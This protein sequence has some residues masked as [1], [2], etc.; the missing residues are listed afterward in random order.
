MSTLISRLY[1]WATDKTNGVKI[2]ASKMDAENDQII[3]ALN[4]KVLCS[5][6]A[7]DS[8]IAGQTWVDTTN[9]LLKVYLDN[10]WKTISDDDTL[11]ASIL[12][13]MYPVGSVYIN[14]S[15]ATNPGT[16]LGFG[17][18][19][20]FGAGKVLVGL[21]AA[22]EDFDTAEETGGAKT[23][24][25]SHTHT[26]TTDVANAGTGANSYVQGDSGTHADWS[27][28]THD[29]TTDSGGSETQSVVQP[30]ITV[31]MWKRTE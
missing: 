12:S 15:V 26:G 14:A 22:D 8:P 25:I 21:N 31:Y 6:S 24:D 18:W 10:T 19:T 9:K 17:T 29:F 5:S 2:T 3:T 4:R 11:E 27:L 28:I 7:P 23:V 30:Y 16:L 1:N 13:A 20:A